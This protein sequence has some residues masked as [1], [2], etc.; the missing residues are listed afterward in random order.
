MSE[1]NA[2]KLGRKLRVL[3]AKS[4][5]S[6]RDVESRTDLDKHTISY[7]ERGMRKRPYA[8]TLAKLANVY[9]VPVEDLLNEMGDIPFVA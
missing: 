6:L 2:R 9:G 4:G 8:R 7:L 5:L 1:D 3:R